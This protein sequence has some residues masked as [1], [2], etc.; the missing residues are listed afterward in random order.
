M[1]DIIMKE[2]QDKLESRF[3]IILAKSGQV[4]DSIFETARYS[5]LGKGKRIRPILLLEFY[6]LCGG[7]D[8]CAYNFACAVE[9]IHTYSLIHDDLPCMDNDDMRRGKPS[10]HKEYGEDM[11]LLAGDGLLTEAFSIAS[12][13]LG[14]PA[15]RVV[16]AI[17]YLSLCAGMNGMVAGQVMDIKHTQE[18]EAEN[19]LTM[20]KLKTGALLK[21]ACVCGTILAGADEEKQKAAADYAE[22]LGLAFQLVDDILDYEGDEELL[23]K[24]IGS[25]DKNG[26]LTLVK[27]IGIDKARELASKFTEEAIRTL[28]AFENDTGDISELT[29]YLLSRKN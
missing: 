25:D 16:K 29:D 2:Y 9:M 26:K 11:A 14:I 18:D 13:T 4:Y 19:I 10:C 23:G 8:D 28:E 24:P 27:L 22:K 3:D 15:E 1:I 5:L 17:S 7:S 20:Y 6:K 21:A 12:K